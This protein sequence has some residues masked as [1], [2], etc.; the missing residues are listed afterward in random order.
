MTNARKPAMSALTT[1]L[2]MVLAPLSKREEKLAIAASTARLATESKRPK[3]ARYRVL[4]AELAIDRPEVKGAVPKRR[5]RVLVA[6]YSARRNLEYLVEGGSVI[7]EHVL[8]FQPAFHEDEI[9]EARDLATRDAR[10]KA[11]ITQR[12][13]VVSAASPERP[14]KDRLLVLRYALVPKGK[15]ASFVATVAVDLSR[16]KVVSVVEGGPINPRSGHHG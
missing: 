10:V 8:S 2:K 5:I 11:F 13:L 14:S 6:D 7:E 1:K 4:G 16:R 9:A 3:E 15:P 12:G